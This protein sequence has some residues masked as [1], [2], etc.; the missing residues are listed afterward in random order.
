MFEDLSLL[1]RLHH[2]LCNAIERGDVICFGKIHR[3]GYCQKHYNRIRKF[4]SVNLPVKLIKICKFIDCGLAHW[5]KGYCQ[6]HYHSQVEKTI[7]ANKGCSV[8]GCKKF[9]NDATTICPMHRARMVKFA[10]LE[11]SGKLPGE[12]TRFKV[13]HKTNIKPVRFCIVSGCDKDSDKCEI[14]KGLCP[15]HYQRWNRHRNY[16]FVLKRGKKRHGCHS[17]QMD[18]EAKEEESRRDCT[19]V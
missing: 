8:I 1:E 7:R 5:G 4:N 18:R 13:G 10:S 15:K 17:E 9:S 19:C 16:N 2:G 3:K 14:T 11:G 6:K 12:C